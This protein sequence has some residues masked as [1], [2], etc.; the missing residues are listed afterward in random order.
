MVL[1]DKII[2]G[3]NIEDKVQTYFDIN[4]LYL[5]VK[6]SGLISWKL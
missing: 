2:R 3:I 6:P 1:T 4:G 5:E